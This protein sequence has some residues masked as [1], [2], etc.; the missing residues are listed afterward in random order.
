M[1]IEQRK[2]KTIARVPVV[3]LAAGRGS[4]L[5]SLTKSTPKCLLRIGRYPILYY[6]IRALEACG[7]RRLIIV[8][9]Y[10]AYLV[11]QYISEF[12]PAINVRYVHNPYYRT[13]GDLYSFYLARRYCRQGVLQ[14]NSDVLFDVDTL[15]TLLVQRGSAICL[16]RGTCGTE[17]LKAIV[18]P[19]TREV[20][21]LSKSIPAPDA[22]G[23]S[24]GLYHFTAT[25]AREFFRYA[26][27]LFQR[28]RFQETRATAITGVLERGGILF[29]ADVTG[30]PI[31]EIDFPADISTAKRQILPDIVIE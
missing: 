2:R 25:F 8:T 28:G 26:G 21:A 3:I 29:Y 23:E 5:G 22:H 10:R 30:R 11:R 20:V 12:F 19:K 27:G 9:G 4:R 15:R 6:Q 16:R 7:F 31:M 13:K 17:E 18:R 1:A 14:I 24:M